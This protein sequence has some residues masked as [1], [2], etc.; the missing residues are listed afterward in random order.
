[1]CSLQLRILQSVNSKHYLKLQLNSRTGSK[2]SSI[3]AFFHHSHIAA[4]LAF[5]KA[6]WNTRINDW[7]RSGSDINQ[8]NGTMNDWTPERLDGWMTERLTDRT[9]DWPTDRLNPQ[10]HLISCTAATDN[11]MNRRITNKRASSTGISQCHL[12][13]KWFTNEPTNDKPTNDKGTNRKRF[14]RENNN[15]PRSK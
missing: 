3:C 10:A 15:N 13:E 7:Y 8:S 5:L 9:A 11:D 14:N 1:M 12:R 2:L 4:R 6:T